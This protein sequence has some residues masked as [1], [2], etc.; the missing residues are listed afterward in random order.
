MHTISVS[1]STLVPED[2]LLLGNGDLSV[3]VYQTPDRVIFRFGK[4]DV[5]DRRLDLSG[6][7]RPAHIDEVTRGIRDEGWKCGPYGGPVEATRGT[8]DPQR[9]KELCQG[10]PPSYGGRPTPCPKPLG[11]LAVYL[12]A[13]Q[14]GL[15]V[16]QELAIEEATLRVRCSWTSGVTL[17]L[18][19]FVHPH[20]NV[21]VL[22]WSLG[23]WG[24]LT[25][26]GRPQ[27]PVRFALYRWA[28]PDFRDFQAHYFG[29]SRHPVA[30]LNA[31]PNVP[32][33]PPPL[34]R[35]IQELHAIEQSFPAEQTFPQGFRY[36]MAP[37]AP[38][39]RVQPLAMAKTGEARLHLLPPD[40]TRQSWVAVGVGTSGDALGPEGEIA[41]IARLLGSEAEAQRTLVT[42]EAENRAA[43][44]LFWARS[45]L[46]SADPLVEDLWYQ[47]LHIRRCAYRSDTVPPG[48]FLPS[49]VLDY[50]HWH[51]D[52]HS[53]YNFQEPFW[54]DCAAN[55]VELGDAFFAGMRY[56]FQMGRTLARDYYN[57]RG[58]FIQLSAYPIVTDGDVI[59]VV[60]MGRMAYMTGWVTSHYWWRYRSTMDL[61]WLREVG[62][63]DI[64][65][66]A[67]FYTDFLKRGE[68]GRYHA[69][70]SN[71]GEDGFTG[72]PKDYT[73]RPQI[74]RHARYCLRVAI[75][76]SEALGADAELRSTWRTIR[77]A[78]APEDGNP[79]RHADCYRS[80]RDELCPPEF[81]AHDGQPREAAEKAQIQA[82]HD[83]GSDLWTWYCGKLAW[84]W[85]IALRTGAWRAD[86]DFG[87]V[88][89]LIQR[90]RHPNGLLWGMAV[91][92]YGHSGAW[93][94][95]LGIIGPLQEMM[96]QSWDGVLRLFPACPV[97]L[98]SRFRDWRAEG[99]FLVSAAWKGG[100][101][102]EV[103]ITSEKGEPCTLAEPWPGGVV[104]TDDRG[105]P[106]SVERVADG[107][108]SF[109]TAPG[110]TYALQPARQ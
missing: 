46:Q 11:E 79:E 40:H 38:G 21:L 82:L 89:A 63:P 35:E 13:D 76:A 47:T 100:A 75:L 58:A 96:L 30:A 66:C 62:Y 8:K 23:N 16:T 3:S 15:A 24:E 87:A 108:V 2:G 61:A 36:L 84:T 48:L 90:W 78:L 10:A 53:N 9:M 50:S 6:D 27:A 73:D 12:P 99:A 72:D 33:L 69:F 91:Q 102:A 68:D 65:D 57:C 32:P 95:T 101:V 19:A 98:E 81:L 26:T 80:P 70:P 22:S 85:M 29:D 42:W 94:E 56:F 25:R 49:T 51:G 55:H 93:T 106:V 31:H 34:L 52:Y 97:E 86:R 64:R 59:G 109:R 88:R 1:G 7:P 67:L 74:V 14:P 71:Q 77:D 110:R 28:D 41:Q 43:A 45:S 5:W 37:W 92:N 60:P 83:R 20:R 105:A 17:T 4:G 54:G 39:C 44:R 103:A 18:S 107:V 104:V